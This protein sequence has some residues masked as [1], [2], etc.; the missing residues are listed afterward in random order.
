MP[1]AQGIK[2]GPEITLGTIRLLGVPAERIKTR[3]ELRHTRDQ[4][5]ERL[6]ERYE[7]SSFSGSLGP[8][9]LSGESRK[10]EKGEEK[11]DDGDARPHCLRHSRTSLPGDVRSDPGRG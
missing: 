9:L 5:G 1:L 10:G 3:A 2:L 8:C 6:P 7:E 4:V 11:E